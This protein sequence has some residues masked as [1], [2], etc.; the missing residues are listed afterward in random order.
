MSGGLSTS[1]AQPPE[2]SV[3]A[4]SDLTPTFKSLSDSFLREKNIRIR[5]IPGSS[6]SLARQIE[7]GA[8]Y[9][10]F[11]SANEAYIKQLTAAGHLKSPTIQHYATGRL[12]LFAKRTQLRRLEALSD[13]AV[14][15]IAIANPGH[16]PYGMAAREV[17]QKLGLWDRLQPKLVYGES[18]HQTLQLAESGNAEIALVSWS[19]VRT[20]G[21][22]LI[23][24]KLHSP[25]RQAGAAANERGRPFLDWLVGPTAQ[26][27]LHEYGFG[28]GTH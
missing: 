11:L 4:A 21:G 2:I 20:K 17:L 12:A 6:G 8:P 28:P 10:A 13:P 1:F 9:D 15:H 14:R 26:R 27:I 5:W 22:I 7:G 23:D 18:V 24:Q 25:L 16:A 19:H 3:A